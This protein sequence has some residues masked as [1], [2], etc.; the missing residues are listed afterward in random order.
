MNNL[1]LVS[2]IFL[3]VF[4]CV[5][6]YKREKCIKKDIQ[7]KDINANKTFFKFI[8][9]IL[10]QLIFFKSNN[11]FEVFKSLILILKTDSM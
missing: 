6:K 7:F 9:L 2:E 8:S 10:I 11:I 4:M 1:T 3:L 5:K